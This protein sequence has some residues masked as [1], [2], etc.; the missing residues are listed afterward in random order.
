[1]VGERQ[2]FVGRA[3]DLMAV[4]GDE[5]REA[6]AG[7]RGYALEFLDT[8]KYGASRGVMDRTCIGIMARLYKL[9]GEEKQ[10]IVELVHRLGASSEDQLRGYV[11]SAKS[12]EGASA[13]DAAERCAAF[14][15]LYFD[16]HPEQRAPLVRRMGGYVPVE[17][18]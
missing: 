16:V 8:L 1:M 5:I 17:V 4:A 18:S 9:T 11:S 6:L 3:K 15:V 13:D 14:L 12:V 7:D 2:A 10:L